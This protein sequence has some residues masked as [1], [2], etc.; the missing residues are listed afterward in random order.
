M[1]KEPLEFLSPLGRPSGASKTPRQRSN[2]KSPRR[3]S[4]PLPAYLQ[5]CT[6]K[7]P[8]ALVGW[9]SPVCWLAGAPA[10]RQ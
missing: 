5:V 3:P 2:G 1:R 7:A 8:R 6:R 4:R 9:L 10:G